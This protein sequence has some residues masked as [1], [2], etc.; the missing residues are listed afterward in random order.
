MNL[1]T[2]TEIINKRFKSGISSEHTYRTDLET[3]IRALVS[4]V[5]IT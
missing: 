5:E 3:L 1:N 2:Y 4:G